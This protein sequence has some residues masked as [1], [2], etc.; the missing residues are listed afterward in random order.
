MRQL[1]IVAYPD[2]GIELQMFLCCQLIKQYVMLGADSCQFPNLI[3]LVRI[4]EHLCQCE[5][6]V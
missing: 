4:P 2:P 3:H 1:H 5:S 6:G